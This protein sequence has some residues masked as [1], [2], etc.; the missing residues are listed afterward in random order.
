MLPG[1]CAG[2]SANFVANVLSKPGI[3]AI[4]KI[5]QYPVGHYLNASQEGPFV[6]CRHGGW[7][8]CRLHSFFMCAKNQSV[9]EGPGFEM[10][11]MIE[12]INDQ[13]G[14]NTDPGHFPT[15]K[16]GAVE[17]CAGKLR[18]DY[19]KLFACSRSDGLRLQ[20]ESAAEGAKRGIVAAPTLFVNGK[21]IQGLDVTLKMVCD[22][23]TGAAPDACKNLA[24]TEAGATK[25]DS[26]RV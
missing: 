14:Y 19:D 23:Y 12:C 9:S 1:A 22:A 18:L 13:L 7:A 25:V 17:A 26:C 8:E 5:V 11:D 24:A 10:L 21:L 20:T 16:E 6:Y 2:F 3:H 15:P 4:V